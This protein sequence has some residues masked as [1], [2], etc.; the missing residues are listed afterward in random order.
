MNFGIAFALFMGLA[1]GCGATYGILYTQGRVDGKC[2]PP[3]SRHMYNT[4]DQKVVNRV[5]LL[6]ENF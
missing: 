3:Q 4:L 1:D 6:T 5:F 2:P